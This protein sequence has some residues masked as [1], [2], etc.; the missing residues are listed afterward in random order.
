MK[1][2]AFIF[3]SWILLA[4]PAVASECRANLPEMPFDS[5]RT[6]HIAIDGEVVVA[7]GYR[8]VSPT[9]AANVKSVSK[10]LM[11]AMVGAA[12][13]KGVI[14]DVNARVADL[15]PDAL[16]ADPDPRLSHLTVSHLLSMQSGLR[17]TSGQNYGAWV[18]SNDWTRS[19]LGQ[20]VEQA[21]GGQMRYST[22]NTHV[23]SAILEA[24]AGQASYALANEWLAPADIRVAD[25]MTSP[26]G[27]AFGGNQIAMR[28][29]ALI[30]LGE[31]YRNDGV[32]PNG[33]RLLPEGWVTESWQVR[34]HSRWT[35]DGYGYGWF[36]RSFAGYAG[37]YGWGYG[38]QML[39]VIPDLAM[40]VAITSDTNR[41]SGRTGYRDALHDYV[42]NLIRVGVC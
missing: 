20:P 18:A 7:N 33:Q 29:E 22:G 8:G 40:T 23:L 35:G 24:Q 34:A 38:G 13:A 19:A 25:W 32:A 12:I 27:V 3:L 39:Y 17:R 2:G 15:L 31:L 37:Y 26:E 6:L 30:A 11:G 21:P 14:S 5:L 41:P 10:T 16:P 36:T 9:A 28:P 4:T 42:A 1:Y